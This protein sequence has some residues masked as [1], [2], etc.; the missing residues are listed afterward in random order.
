VIALPPSSG[1]VTATVIFALPRV[2]PGWA[3]ADGSVLGTTGSD[4][5]DGAPEPFAFVAV[6]V[7]VYDFP[8]VSAPTTSGDA[9]PDAKP[10]APPFDDVH[11]A[12]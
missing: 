7:H 1:A 6:T 4:A 11:P 12:P 10:G 5:G 3:G 9:V 2:T 8:F